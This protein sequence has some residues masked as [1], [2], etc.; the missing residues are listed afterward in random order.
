MRM[1]FFKSSAASLTKVLCTC[2]IVLS[3]VTISAREYDPLLFVRSFNLQPKAEM[4]MIVLLHVFSLVSMVKIFFV[5]F[6][7]SAG[8]F[9]LCHLCTCKRNQ[10]RCQTLSGT[11]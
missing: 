11:I 8:C 7:E 9:C 2:T 10:S 5:S 1:L 3:K 6:L 4:I